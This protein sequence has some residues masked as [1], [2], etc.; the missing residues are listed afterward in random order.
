M[1]NDRRNE[2]IKYLISVNYQ[3][4]GPFTLE[5][6]ASRASKREFG[7]DMYVYRFP[8]DNVWRPARSIPELSDIL[9]KHFPFQPGDEGPAGGRVIKGDTSKLFEISPTDAGYCS[10]ENAENICKNF[11]FNG[12]NNWR[13]PTRDELSRSAWYISEQVRDE[14]KT[15]QTNEFILHWSNKREKDKAAAV[16]TCIVEDIYV[17]PVSSK[18]GVTTAGHYRNKDDIERGNE[19]MLSITE[20]H[21]VRPVRDL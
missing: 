21:P 14:K 17:P 1:S 9:L 8:K 5:E 10:W 20:W 19:K 16:Y 2:T 6:L 7:W 12:Y 15:A 11:S 4:Y 13:L 18:K 3:E